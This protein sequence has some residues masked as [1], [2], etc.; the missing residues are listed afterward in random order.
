MRERR[1]PPA[2]LREAEQ[3]FAELQRTGRGI[4]W[5][6]MRRYLLRRALG[7]PVARPRPSGART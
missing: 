4:E 1:L 7:L 5:R 6:K 3:R 2:L